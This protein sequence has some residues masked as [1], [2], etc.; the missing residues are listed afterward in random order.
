MSE[1]IIPGR[2]NPTS[3]PPG[4]NPVV[5]IDIAH[6]DNGV[7]VTKTFADGTKTTSTTPAAPCLDYYAVPNDFG[8]ISCATVEKGSPPPAGYHSGPWDTLAECEANF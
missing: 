2:I 5:D 7:A 3:L 6:S 1:V 8:G 4:L